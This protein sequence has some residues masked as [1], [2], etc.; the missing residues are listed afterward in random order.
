MAEKPDKESRTE[1]PTE[2]KIRDAIDR[3]NTPVSREAS[4]FASLLGSLLF[5]GF[6]LRDGVSALVSG[7]Q[8]VLDDAGNLSLRNGG[9]AVA[10]FSVVLMGAARF[11]API[12]AILIV[13]GLVASLAQN[14]P[15]IVFDRIQPDFSRVSPM[16][17]W[18]RLFGAQG[19]IEFLKSA[20]KLLAISIV[21]ALLLRTEFGN[22]FNALFLE[23]AALPEL[24]LAIAFRLLAAVCVAALLLVTADL[25]WSRFHWHEE[26]RMTRQEV[27]DELKQLEGDP[28]MKSRLRS[29]ALDRLRKS[30]MAQVP[31]A[32]L[33]IA[34]PTHYAIA[35]RYVREE[36]GA[37]MVLAK[38]KDLIALRIREIAEDH[39]IPV[40]E[41][42][43]LARSLYDSVEVNR[44]IPSEFYRAV[45]EL[46][47][48]LYARNQLRAPSR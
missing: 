20:F 37:P 29:L 1:E 7:L 28:L 2:K 46:I 15:R 26:L 38:G 24:V 14:A 12:F 25:L 43:A 47:H 3:G 27:K 32:T 8:R 31:R 10:L 45:A 23:P 39:Q 9:D 30:M 41:D 48:F 11:L 35:L 19:Q 21:V 34:N 5:A 16:A 33:V 42:K 22:L 17:G 40:I 18:K 44:M 6:M 13:F 36:G 4:V